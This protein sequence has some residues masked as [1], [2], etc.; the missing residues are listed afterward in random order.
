MQI[1]NSQTY[2][3]GLSQNQMPQGSAFGNPT[4]DR[5]IVTQQQ[6]WFSALCASTS[7][8]FGLKFYDVINYSD[9]TFPTHPHEYTRKVCFIDVKTITKI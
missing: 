3:I 5:K 1:K 4:T 8:C 7:N 9:V 2:L 6:A